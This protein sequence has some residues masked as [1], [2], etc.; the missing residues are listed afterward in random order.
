ML[1]IR[2]KV[3]QLNVWSLRAVAVAVW[4]WAVVEGQ[5]KHFKKV[6]VLP[7]ECLILLLWAPAALAVLG[8]TLGRRH[9]AVRVIRLVLEISFCLAVV[10]E[11]QGII[12]RILI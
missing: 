9:Q 1:Q 2:V 11:G 8:P 7:W 10:A 6:S 3:L 12:F 4:T 5:V